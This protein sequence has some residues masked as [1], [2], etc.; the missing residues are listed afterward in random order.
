MRPDPRPGV[1]AGTFGLTGI[2]AAAAV[3]AVAAVAGVAVVAAV[4]LATPGSARADDGRLLLAD[5]PVDAALSVAPTGV[6]LSFTDT[7]QPELS[8]VEVFDGAGDEVT[9]GDYR[10]VAPDRV[11][12]PVQIG[13]D[14]DYTVAYHVTFPDGSDVT[15]VYRFSVGTGVPPAALDAAT[16]EARTDAVSEHAHEIDGF[17]ATLL[18]IDGLV[19]F[20]VI[21]LLWLRP[22]DGRPTSLRYRDP[23]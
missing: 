9:D 21:A 14:G 18:V 11:H 17:S 12:Q 22:R 5:P 23:D 3:V 6:T 8:H 15:D 4:L 20:V 16:R 2:V 1:P 10:Q 7:V 19:L 13:A